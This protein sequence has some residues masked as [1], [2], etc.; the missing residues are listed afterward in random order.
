MG[1][2]KGKL[3]E[4]LSG[5]YFSDQELFEILSFL[6]DHRT[7]AIVY[8]GG[9]ELFAWE[10]AFDLI[11]RVTLFGLKMVIFTNGTLL[12]RRD[13]ARLNSFGAVLIVS[14]R[15]TVERYHNAAV[16][17]D[18]FSR[19]L[20]TIENALSEGFHR[21]SRLAVEIPVTKENE[22]RVL[23]DFLPAMRFLGIV[24][25]IEEY[26]QISTSEVE[27]DRSHTFA[28][29]R[30]FF[31]KACEKDSNLGV[32]WTPERAQR[33]IDQPQCKRPLYSFA[34]FPSG[35]VLDCPSHSRCYGNFKK[36]SLHEVIYSDQFKASI[37]DFSLCACSVFY[38]W[39]DTEVPHDLP[40][41]LEVFR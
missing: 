1:K 36:S 41:C 21:D 5:P 30:T 38:T 3:P 13:L 35:D 11:E 20:S 10:G 22:R 8:G 26:I 31:K 9:G 14:L 40:H 4:H 7:E 39:S 17:I 2:D 19:T 37:L 34:I 15:D 28:Q 12:S 27:R 6:R 33:M 32:F 23:D 16:G 25:M 24:P 29:S 18:G